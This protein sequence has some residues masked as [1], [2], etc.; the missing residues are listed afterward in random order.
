MP[1]NMWQCRKTAEKA[2]LHILYS[3]LHIG[4]GVVAR[5]WVHSF[6]TYICCSRARAKSTPEEAFNFTAVPISCW[7]AVDLKCRY[8]LETRTRVM[9]SCPPVA[10]KTFLG[11]LALHLQ[12]CE[13]LAGLPSETT[14]TTILES[15]WYKWSC[16]WYA[17]ARYKPGMLYITHYLEMCQ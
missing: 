13:N 17:C 16:S 14:F 1:F 5:L 2:L 15:R 8:K 10:E 11:E 12:I 4:G 7:N 6:Q 9:H 3:V